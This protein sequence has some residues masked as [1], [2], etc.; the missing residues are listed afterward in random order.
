MGMLLGMRK[1]AKQLSALEVTRLDRPG[2]HAVGG[3]AGLLL[4]VR[5]SA[6]DEG[7]PARSWIL[8][9]RFAGKRHPIGLGPYPQ[10][11]LAEARELARKH[12]LEIRGGVDPLAQK[13]ARRSALIAAAAKNKTFRECAEAYMKAHASDYTNDKHRKQWESTLVAYA[14]PVIGRMLV[15]D[16][17]MRN[18]LDVLEQETKGF[19][20]Q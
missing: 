20:E 10:V 18:V 2:W 19:A 4:Q 6:R 13:R 1:V 17:T 9:L 15:A 14:Y 16:V 5:K 3:V 7:P 8:R 11:S 12:C